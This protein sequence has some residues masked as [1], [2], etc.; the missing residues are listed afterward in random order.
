MVIAG[1]QTY[2][3]MHAQN[4]RRHAHTIPT[5][6]SVNEIVLL[7]PVLGRFVNNDPQIV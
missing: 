2:S 5:C 7:T 6:T 3:A 1:L 4:T